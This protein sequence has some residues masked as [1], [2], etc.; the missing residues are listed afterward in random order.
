MGPTAPNGSLF[1]CFRRRETSAP[2]VVVVDVAI[3][4][5]KLLGERNFHVLALPR[6]PW[7]GRAAE[8]HSD[9]RWLRKP[10]YPL[11]AV[12]SYYAR[13]G[14]SRSCGETA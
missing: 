3:V 10:S 1:E 6:I 9:S 5:R 12:R 13:Y 4:A 8:R 14:V 7:P 11:S 2:A